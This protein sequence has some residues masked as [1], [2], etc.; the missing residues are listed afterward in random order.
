[1]ELEIAQD[2][3]SISYINELENNNPTNNKKIN[4]FKIN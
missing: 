2:R 3:Y 4:L 1:M